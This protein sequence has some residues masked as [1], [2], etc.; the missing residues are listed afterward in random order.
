MRMRT[1]WAVPGLLWLAALAGCDGVGGTGTLSIQATDEP[2][3]HEYVQSAVIEVTHVDAHVQA[4]ATSG[5][6]LLRSEP[7][8][9]DLVTLRDGLTALLAEAEVPA[10]AYRQVRLFLG[11]ASLTLSKDGET[12]TYL[13]SDGTIQLSSQVE[14][15]FKVFLVPAASVIDGFST[16][17]LFDFDLTRTYVA[18]D[19]TDP[20]DPLSA[21]TYVLNP[22]IRVSNLSQTG[23]IRGQV[24]DESSGEGVADATVYVYWGGEEVANT[25]SAADGSYAILGLPAATYDVA[26]QLG[27]RQAEAP[28]VEVSAGS[29]TVVDLSLP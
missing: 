28:G 19:A 1:L 9:L 24:A 23:E 11:E 22:V 6:V 16:E 18:V 21:S 3:A 5:F 13:T 25:G 2:F 27:T 4:D 10:G 20:E 29:V 14:T 26:V 15:G 17:L 7:I 12:R 8:V